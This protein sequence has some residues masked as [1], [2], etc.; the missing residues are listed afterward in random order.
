MAAATA[1]RRFMAS[2]ENHHVTS[3]PSQRRSASD[4]DAA[5]RR[6]VGDRARV[7]PGRERV[8]Y[9]VGLQVILQIEAGRGS[10]R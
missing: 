7:D 5:I 4:E 1:V 6:N 2:P 9:A 8:R 3:E 10:I